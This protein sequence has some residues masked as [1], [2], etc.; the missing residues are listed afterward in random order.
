MKI[1]YLCADPGIS[2]EKC[3]GSAAHVR[4][5][6][7]SFCDLGH[8]VVLIMSSTGGTKDLG[9]PVH[10]VPVPGISSSLLEEVV[11]SDDK[12]GGAGG[13]GGRPIFRALRHLWNNVATEQ[14]LVKV[15]H[16]YQPDL[17]YERYS[18]FSVAGG[19]LARREGIP[20]ILEVNAP[21]A[22][23][24]AQY[25]NQALPEVAEMLERTAFGI[26]S[27]IV[28]VSRELGDELVAKGVPGSKIV[29]VPNG[30]DPGKFKPQGRTYQDGL[31]GKFVVGFVGSLKA[32][33][34]VDVLAEAF[35]M[36]ASDPRLHLLVVGDGPMAGLLRDLENELPG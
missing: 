4:N 6:V 16:R 7:R 28:A 22:R 33:H 31:D 24:G 13:K 8:D 20:H 2:L 17:I 9:V 3:N 27:C 34:G 25:R 5:I 36:L 32:W 10:G 35:K 1:C 23:E 14:A 26:A 12:L 29:V 21:L 18:P 19:L 11:G 15:L 30:V